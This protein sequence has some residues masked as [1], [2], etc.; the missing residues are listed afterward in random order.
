MQRN[1]DD[2]RTDGMKTKH[3]KR[4]NTLVDSAIVHHCA[5]TIYTAFVTDDAFSMNIFLDR[6]RSSNVLGKIK[7][8]WAEWREGKRMKKK[9]K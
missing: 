9:Q 3:L 6:F 4:F 2:E 5:Y 8:E 1:D 7:I